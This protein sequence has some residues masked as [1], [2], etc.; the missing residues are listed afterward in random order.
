MTVKELA[1]FFGKS[2]DTI[3]RHSKK[4]GILFENGTKKSFDQNEVELIANSLYKK[5]PSAIKQSIDDAFN[6]SSNAIGYTTANAEVTNMVSEAFIAALN[7]ITKT[8]EMILKRLEA[9]ENKNTQPVIEYKQDYFTILAY[10]N[11][12]GIRNMELSETR[13][14]SHIAKKISIENNKEIR[15]IPDERWGKLNSY[16]IEVLK[17][18][19]EI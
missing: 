19:F 14:L 11:Y 7:S 6:T 5:L 4:L 18:V 16:H 9:I 13:R 2:D 17:K 1:E 15:I 10:A 8:N 3:L 12:N